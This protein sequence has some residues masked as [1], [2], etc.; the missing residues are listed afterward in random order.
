MHK[1]YEKFNLLPGRSNKGRKI[2]GL[3]PNEYPITSDFITLV[4]DEIQE[5][6]RTADAMNEL[7]LEEA[8]QILTPCINIRDTFQE[9]LKNYA[10]IFEGYT[11]IDNIE[12]EQIVSYDISDLKEMAPNIFD[13][14]MYSLLWMCWSTSV[15]NGAIMKSKWENGEIEWEDIVRTASFVMKHIVG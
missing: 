3:M 14:Q 12:D 10:S 2:T 8:R 11:S 1:L 6:T 9:L 5:L 15:S 13:A 7:E 4:D